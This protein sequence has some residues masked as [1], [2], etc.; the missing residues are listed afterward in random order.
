MPTS[1]EQYLQL[2]HPTDVARFGA[3][4]AIA[5]SKTDLGAGEYSVIY[6][7]DGDTAQYQTYTHNKKITKIGY[8]N[9]GVL[10]FSDTSL[11][12]YTLDRAT[13]TKRETGINSSTF[14]IHENVFY[15][16]QVSQ[17]VTL[18]SYVL[19]AEG[20]P[21]EERQI[22]RIDDTNAQP[23]LTVL[24]NT[25]LCVFPNYVLGYAQGTETERFQ[26]SSDLNKTN[27][28]SSVCAFGGELYYTASNGLYRYEHAEGSWKNG[29][30]D[31][32]FST[33]NLSA[34]NNFENTLFCIQN[35]SVRE[36]AVSEQGT[37]FTDYEICAS[38]DSKNRL[39]AGVQTARSGDLLATADSENA[40]VSLYDRAENSY[41]LISCDYLPA[42][43]A[44]DTANG[45]QTLAVTD[46]ANTLAVYKNG[47]EA[48]RAT[49]S[50]KI[51]GIA[52]VYGSVYY[53]TENNGY[54]KATAAG[55]LTPSY[56]SGARPVAL[57][58]DMYGNLYVADENGNVSC[59]KENDFTLESVS[60]GVTLDYTLPNGF[61]SLKADF[62]GNLYCLAGNALYQNG[63]MLATVSA[64]NC[65]YRDVT[66]I[67]A[68]LSFA[69]GYEDNEVYFLFDNFTLKTQAID[70]PT[71]RRL[72]Y[73]DIP[74]T[75][76][77]TEETPQIVQIGSGAVGITTD[78]EGLKTAE[79]GFFPYEGYERESEAQ[80]GVLLA[81]TEKYALVSLYQADENDYVAKLFHREKNEIIAVAQSEFWQEDTGVRYLSSAVSPYFYPCLNAPLGATALSRQQ[82]VTLLAT[83]NGGDESGYGYA[84]VEYAAEGGSARGYVP[85]SYL[86]S[87]IPMP[88][89]DSF[90]LEYLKASDAGVTFTAQNGDTLT[91]TERA[92]I[93]LAETDDGY[94]AR[95]NVDGVDYTASVTAEQIESPASDALRMSL[96]II[97]SVLAAIILL[98]YIFLVPHKRKKNV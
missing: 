98:V 11:D 4:I 54:G 61:T 32:I 66:T 45:E 23:F 49:T 52:C 93:Y 27:G 5:D 22:S 33:S 7:Y 96:I 8:G 41:S 87:A 12:L 79:D 51:T 90:R 38:S 82:K 89:T 3:L 84:L 9:N 47:E 88:E 55:S 15:N 72:A 76:Y 44:V 14:Y 97:L 64:E 77:S 92:Q 70:F 78:L 43:L 34:L 80:K 75:L 13:M 85:L 20:I 40:R 24:D 21:T 37:D 30:S 68:P 18:T 1:Y 74:D 48:F 58:S 69:L 17:G 73:D 91:L 94:V 67:P 31:Q 57:T 46:G 10:Y 63:E 36:I 35:D 26:L 53:V 39:G 50:M 59:Y 16:A 6:L 56:R 71:L 60:G 42:M 81:Q 62:E 2:T 19:G 29:E 28:L 65:V 86:T 95:V 25:L 83:V